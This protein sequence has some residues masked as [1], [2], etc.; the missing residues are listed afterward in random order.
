MINAVETGAGGFARVGRCRE[1]MALGTWRWARAAAAAAWLLLALAAGAAGAAPAGPAPPGQAGGRVPGVDCQ[2]APCQAVLPDAQWFEP[3]AGDPPVHRGYGRGALGL[4]R[5]VGYV[6]LTTDATR[7]R[8]FGGPIAM[9]VGISQEGVITGVRIIEQH[10]TIFERILPPTLMDRFVAQLPGHPAG[11]D[12]DL[13]FTGA[14]VKVDAITQATVT[15]QALLD[16]VEQ[17]AARVRAAHLDGHGGAVAAPPWWRDLLP[18]RSLAGLALALGGLA[19]GVASFRLRR[20]RLLYISLMGLA[21]GLWLGRPL[22]IWHFLHLLRGLWQAVTGDGLVLLLMAAAV[23]GAPLAGRWFC[24]RLCPFGAVQEWANWLSRWHLPVPPAWHRRLIWIKYSLLG[25]AVGMALLGTEPVVAWTE[26]FGYIFVAVPS[27]LAGIYLALLLVGS[28]LVS[29]FY[30]R[31]LCPLGALLGLL[32][33][34][35]LLPI[36][37]AAACSRCQICPR[38]CPVQAIDARGRISSLECIRCD[39]CEVNY[40]NVALCP[41]FARARMEARRRHAD[42][43]LQQV[44]D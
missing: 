35:P 18:G 9:L 31:Y 23:L 38:A 26:P 14:A 39:A 25:A 4:R 11:A 28:A 37:R 10:E 16:A 42:T 17:S 34:R 30:C 29:R 43:E 20:H 22:S 40:A 8:G 7:V 15:S 3:V 41:R 1:V 27:V 36:R 44:G 24:G 21:V 2:A 33:A 32:S 12:F 13:Q 19:A 5:P 6:V